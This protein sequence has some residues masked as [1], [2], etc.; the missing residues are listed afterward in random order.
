MDFVHPDDREATIREARKMDQG[1]LTIFIESRYRSADGT[2]L[3]LLWNATPNKS[4][5]L[6]FRGGR[7]DITQRK[8]TERRLATGYA[9]QTLPAH[10]ESLDSIAP[11]ILKAICEGL[12]W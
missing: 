12:G 6:I 7:V 8:Q 11:Q 4:L 10:A 1:E 3:W 2:Y 9:E 5:K